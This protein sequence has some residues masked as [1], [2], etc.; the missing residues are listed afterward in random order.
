MVL[1]KILKGINSEGIKM[2]K[3]SIF[4]MNNILLNKI[5]LANK[6]S[7]FLSILS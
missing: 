5:N 2:G 4:R 3:T 6:F 1:Q 7:Q